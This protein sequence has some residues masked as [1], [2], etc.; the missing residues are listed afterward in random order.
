MADTYASAAIIPDL[1]V[2]STP[3]IDIDRTTQT[4]K[5]SVKK[6]EKEGGNGT[7]ISMQ[8]KRVKP[9]NYAN[10]NLERSETVLRRQVSKFEQWKRS[11]EDREI[12]TQRFVECIQRSYNHDFHDY[13]VDAAHHACYVIHPKP[14]QTKFPPGC[15][16]SYFPQQEQ[17]SVSAVI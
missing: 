6:R 10:Q 4:S 1:V 5:S 12:A 17:N 13:S 16:V 8:M 15:L 2:S 3:I 9:H 7:K 14:Q 11:T